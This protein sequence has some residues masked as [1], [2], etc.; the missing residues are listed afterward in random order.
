MT[1]IKHRNLR[2]RRAT[3]QRDQ[4]AAHTLSQNLQ[5]R[6]P[7]STV[8]CPPAP[9]THTHSQERA[10]CWRVTPGALLVPH[11]RSQ[12]FAGSLSLSKR[13]TS[14]FFRRHRQT[15]ARVW[16]SDV[17]TDPFVYI[18]IS[19]LIPSCFLMTSPGLFALFHFAYTYISSISV[20]SHAPESPASFFPSHPA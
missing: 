6:E 11:L 14:T 13:G 8:S 17:S 2:A 3:P 18:F 1:D 5:G 4:S 20:L 16:S 7:I 12:P 9:A 15:R 19:N 10:R